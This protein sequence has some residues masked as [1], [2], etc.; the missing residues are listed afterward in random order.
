M[1]GMNFR[2]RHVLALAIAGAADSA[3]SSVALGGDT[4]CSN[5]RQ[6]VKEALAKAIETAVRTCGCG[7]NISIAP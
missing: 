2:R 3:L 7:I 6:P 5:P 4:D 1:N